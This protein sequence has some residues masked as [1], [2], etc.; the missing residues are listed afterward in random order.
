MQ[1]NESGKKVILYKVRQARWVWN[2]W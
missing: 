2:G 1:N